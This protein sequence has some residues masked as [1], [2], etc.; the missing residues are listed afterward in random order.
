M[1]CDIDTCVKA[2]EKKEGST[3][4]YPSSGRVLYS[5]RHSACGV[6]ERGLVRGLV[7]T[8]SAMNQGATQALV[9]AGGVEDGA[10]EGVRQGHRV[11]GAQEGEEK[12]ACPLAVRGCTTQVAEAD[13]LA[14]AEDHRVGREVNP[15]LAGEHPPR[16]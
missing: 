9:G 5:Q 16:V 4:A 11:L 14:E 3:R 10:E 15:A 2:T 7:G 13:R 12:A 8:H 6:E 1:Q